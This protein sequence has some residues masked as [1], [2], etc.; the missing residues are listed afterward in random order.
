[1]IKSILGFVVV[2]VLALSVGCTATGNVK[3]DLTGLWN[4][5]TVQAELSAVESAAI[6]FAQKFITSKLGGATHLKVSSSSAQASIDAAT[7]AIARQHPTL[8]PTVI[9]NIVE[10]K[11][12]ERL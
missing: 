8:P 7:S 2:A 1:M 6:G 9:K 3:S 5:P 4:S 10:A 11:Y 12:A